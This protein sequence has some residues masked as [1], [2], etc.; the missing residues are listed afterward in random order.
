LGASDA[1]PK[2]IAKTG[3]PGTSTDYSRGDHQHALDPNLFPQP[4]DIQIDGVY[5][6]S[7]QCIDF[8]TGANVTLTGLEDAINERVKVTIAS[9]G[10]GSSHEILSATH[11]DALAA[12]VLRGALIVGNSTPKWALLALGT[13]GKV[14]R[15]NGSDALWAALACADL[16]DHTKAVHD[17]LAINADLLDGNEATAFAVAAK[18]V[19]NGDTHDHVGGDGAQ[20]NHTGL[21]NIGTNTHAQ[22]DT[23]LAASAPHGGHEATA[24]K[25]Q[26]SGY[27]PL[28]ASVLVPL[29]NIPA[30]LTGKNA[31]QVDGCHAGVAANDVFKILA[32]IA[33][34]DIFY[35]NAT[36]NI[37]RLAKGTDGQVLKLVSG[38]PAWQTEGGGT[39]HE[40]LSATH[41][42]SLAGTVVRGDVIIG[43]A[44]PK[45]SR[46]ALGTA[47]KVI[48]SDGTDPSWA[49]L[50]H[51]DLSGIGTNT[52][53]QVDTFIASKGAASGLCD[54]DAGSKVAA[55]RMPTGKVKTTLSFAVTG[56]L[57]VGTDKA[58]TLLAPCTLTIT[59]VRLVVKTAPTGADLQV[60]VN[61]NGTSIFNAHGDLKIV[62]GATTGNAA[63]VT[64]AL[65]LDD[66]LTVDI[67]QVGS[68][69]A[70][71]DLTVEVVADQAVTFT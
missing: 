54:L 58:P 35:V 50:A 34:G 47:G 39:S 25:G 45:W 56:T 65:A 63:P 44:T 16:S 11:T 31:D 55:A 1:I 64:T 30:T 42:D 43:N 69:V 27:C 26:A 59:S 17:A 21:S 40:L 22:V 14:L 9:A 53:A 60:D 66:K 4:L 24:N 68:T 8:I 23:H 36:P 2:A 13:S 46:L 62:A 10:G 19:T 67:V 5:I 6:G 38:F 33:S 12:T 57:T 18:G 70:G 48:R 71:A 52:H 3:K 20:I 51:G 32:A 15:S 61:K 28:D 49:Q 29:A 41:T 7:R 37:A